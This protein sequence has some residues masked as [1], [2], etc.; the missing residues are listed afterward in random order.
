M[1][2][3]W[4]D[5]AILAILTYTLFR[6]AAKGI[7]WQL[8][9]IVA[10]LLCF[11][12]SETASPP[13]AKIIPAESP[14]NLWIAMFVIYVACV[15]VTFWGA[16]KISDWMEKHRFKEFDRHLG[17]IFGFVKGVLFSLMVTFFA[18]TLSADAREIVLN[19]NSGYAAA[20][21]MDRLHP[22]MPDDLHDV[23][24]P[25]IHQ[26][27]DAEGNP[28]LL[29]SHHDESRKSGSNSEHEKQSSDRH[30]GEM[31]SKK[32]P[33]SSTGPVSTKTDSEAAER[34]ELLQ[35]IAALHALDAI[36]QAAIIREIEGALS[37][38]PD[39]VELAVLKDWY[40]DL[41]NA[42]DDPDPQTNANTRIE[43]RIFRQMIATGNPLDQL[44]IGLRK[45]L[46]EI[47][48]K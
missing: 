10:L 42:K 23:L 28:E 14:L 25:Y 9:W 30:G 5:V 38:L 8:A 27:D 16:R 32:L 33:N 7:V 35:N 17:A 6:G 4:Y 18:V 44:E 1:T 15:F 43:T 40:A 26:L 3:L 19:S 13:L 11:A 20:I 34:T 48:R 31:S 36:L 21:V 45:R 29:H 22:V 12:I 39:A 46:E 37:G 41:S 24:E 47:R 2:P